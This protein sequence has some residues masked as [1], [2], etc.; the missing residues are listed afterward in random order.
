MLKRDELKEKVI[1]HLKNFGKTKW[2]SSEY[3]FEALE[4]KF[5]PDDKSLFAEQRKRFKAFQ[6][7]LADVVQEIFVDQ[8]NYNQF[9]VISSNKGYKI[10]LTEDECMIGRN[11]LK[12]KV[13]EVLER[14]KFIDTYRVGK[15]GG[16]D[17]TKDLFAVEV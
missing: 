8:M 10:A 16:K 6:R 7:E 13:D 15:Y 11:Y 5:V 17:K 3:F 2:L 4:E 12:S 14:I 9:L 1:F